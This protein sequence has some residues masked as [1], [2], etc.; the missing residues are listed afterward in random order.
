M[1]GDGLRVW[2]FLPA[3]RIAL[4]SN[5]LTSAS[6]NAVAISPNGMHIGVVLA[7]DSLSD[8]A[9][10]DPGQERATQ[11]LVLYSE[12]TGAV[13]KR[14]PRPSEASVS[15]PAIT[16]DGRLIAYRPYSRD[17][18]SSELVVA[19]ATAP[20]SVHS[21]TTIEAVPANGALCWIG[22][23]QRWLL[24]GYRNGTLLAWRRA[25]SGN[26]MTDEPTHVRS[27]AAECTHIASTPDHLW[28]AACTEAEDGVAGKIVVWRATTANSAGQG[29]GD[30]YRVVREWDVDGNIWRVAFQQ[31]TAMAG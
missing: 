20:D 23:E 24:S 5:S 13:V 17:A 29:F 11:Q 4:D 3:R 15:W 14:R 25:D 8:D 7:G 30:A 21:S 31:R 28:V 2:D 1:G 22:P 6:A 16:H 19:D 12:A 27:F 9:T 10:A 18:A 26:E